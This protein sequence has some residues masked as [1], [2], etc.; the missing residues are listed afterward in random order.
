[1]LVFSIWWVSVYG[2]A[3]DDR[4]VVRPRYYRNGYRIGSFTAF[5]IAD[6]NSNGVVAAS[7]RSDPDNAVSLTF[8]RSAIG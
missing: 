1:V 7:V 4:G 5:A 6:S 8:N 2:Q 3:S